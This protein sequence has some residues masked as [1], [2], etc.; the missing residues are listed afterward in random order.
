MDY[1]KIIIRALTIWK[2][3]VSSFNKDNRFISHK[4]EYLDNIITKLNNYLMCIQDLKTTP[5]V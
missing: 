5:N 4:I 2:N 3:K 1:K